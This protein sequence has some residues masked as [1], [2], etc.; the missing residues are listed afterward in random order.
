MSATGPDPRV[1]IVVSGDFGELSLARWFVSGQQFES[2]LLLPPRLHD[3][4]LGVT[5]VPTACYRSASDILA[6]TQT[7]RSDLVVLA[8]GYLYA[9]NGLLSIDDLAGMI[10]ILR[11]R[12]VRM[13]TTDPFLGLLQDSFRSLFHAGHPSGHLFTAHFD[14]VAPLLKGLPHLHPVPLAV[15]GLHCIPFF[16]PRIVASQ[17]ERASHRI[18]V[19]RWLGPRNETSRWLFILSSEDYAGETARR[20]R[21]AFLTGLAARLRE[22]QQAGTLPVVLAPDACLA[23]L[24]ARLGSP[25][26]AILLPFCGI[27]RFESLLL[28]AEFA[29]Y[30]NMFSNSIAMRVLN[31][32]ACFL[33]DRGHLARAIPALHAAGV[34]AYYGGN[35][36]ELLDERVT[37]TT[38]TLDTLGR[39]WT[40][41]LQAVVQHRWRSPAP[42]TI[43]RR[44]LGT[45]DW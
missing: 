25:D 3:R 33:F 15:T 35:E 13:V 34:E 6:H 19:S 26:D 14:A 29:F 44:M 17:D 12:G 1:C 23:G 24:R 45:G 39:P 30:W 28:D 32:L 27:D 18:T 20:G 8:S 16:N 4:N 7:F 38:A 5:G 40:A 37:L 22:A 36:P 21:D 9:I 42:E 31:G 10:G 2:C 43:V 11:D 41:R